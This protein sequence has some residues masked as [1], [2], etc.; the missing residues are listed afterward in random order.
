MLKTL[1]VF[2]TAY[3]VK[4]KYIRIENKVPFCT[5]SKVVFFINESSYGFQTHIS[6]NLQFTNFKLL[7]DFNFYQWRATENTSIKI[8]VD[9]RYSL[10]KK[11]NTPYITMLPLSL[12]L[13]KCMRSVRSKNLI[14]AKA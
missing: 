9:L 10:K 7:L 14:V 8:F 4:K 1:T 12:Q 2:S 13:L 5:K 6:C 3:S 11:L